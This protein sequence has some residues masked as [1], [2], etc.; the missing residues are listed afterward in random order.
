MLQ[1]W[2]CFFAHNSWVSPAP[3]KP[4]QAASF[5]ERLCLRLE[6]NTH[7]PSLESRHGLS[8]LGSSGPFKPLLSPAWHAW[9]NWSCIPDGLSRVTHTISYRPLSPKMHFPERIRIFTLAKK[10][11]FHT[12]LAGGRECSPIEFHILAPRYSVLQPIFSV[13]QQ[14]SFLW[15]SQSDRK[16][17]GSASCLVSWNVFYTPEKNMAK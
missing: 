2:I 17:A 9:W 1:F 7:T 8:H 12:G 16:T 11:S 15:R 10:V 4:E 14:K 3:Q 6:K 13:S 5:E